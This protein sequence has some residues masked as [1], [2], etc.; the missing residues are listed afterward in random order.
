MKRKDRSEEVAQSNREAVQSLG[1]DAETFYLLEGFV[2]ER[3]QVYELDLRKAI[4]RLAQ[5]LNRMEAELQARVELSEPSPARRGA[6]KVPV[7]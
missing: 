7:C 3:R 1:G 5:D 4:A 6:P 2:G